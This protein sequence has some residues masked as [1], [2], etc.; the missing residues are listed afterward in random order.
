VAS[1]AAAVVRRRTLT[2]SHSEQT[3]SRPRAVW[4]FNL[5]TLLQAVQVASLLIALL[6]WFVVNA[7]RGLDNQRRLD[8]LQSSVSGQISDVRQA[9]A[10]GLGEVRQQ[11]GA[12]PDQ[13][14]RLDQAERRIAEIDA[15]YS[16]LE[17][18]IST[19]ERQLVEVRSDMNA[20]TRASNVP[21]PGVRH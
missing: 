16:N 15:R 3:T 21:L 5:L 20:I 7:N 18:R 4:E 9:V 12:L 2:L 1:G 11:L 13:R 17:G 8:E 14:A 6:Y 19:L 10:V